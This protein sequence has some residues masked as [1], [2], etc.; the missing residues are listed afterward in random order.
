MVRSLREWGIGGCDRAHFLPCNHLRGTKRTGRPLIE[1]LGTRRGF[2]SIIC[3]S[4]HRDDDVTPTSILR[5]SVRSSSSEIGRT[6][7]LIK[8]IV[9]N[10]VSQTIDSHRRIRPAFTQRLHPNRRLNRL[11]GP[12]TAWK[13]R[14]ETRPIESSI[15]V[16][17]NSAPLDG[18]RKASGSSTYSLPEPSPR[19]RDETDKTANERLTTHFFDSNIYSFFLQMLRARIIVF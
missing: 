7:P 4:Y 1:E 12:A 19:R 8:S 18:S 11:L 13:Y 5:S 2:F 17:N 16:V 10:A 14:T 3:V 15:V 9:K 6:R